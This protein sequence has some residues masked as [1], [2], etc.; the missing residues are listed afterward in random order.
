MDHGT[1]IAAGNP[2]E[3]QRDPRVI[4][5]YLGTDEEADTA[6]DAT[7]EAALWDS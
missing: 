1:L 6:E 5:A 4:D 7:E 2:A 3:I